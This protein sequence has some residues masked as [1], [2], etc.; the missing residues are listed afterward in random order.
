[1][2]AAVAAGQRTATLSQQAAAAEVARQSE[3]A[4]EGLAAL[5]KEATQALESCR[6]TA[7][8]AEVAEAEVS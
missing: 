1:M 4:E 2:S 8:R 7:V 3:A 5:R 6:A